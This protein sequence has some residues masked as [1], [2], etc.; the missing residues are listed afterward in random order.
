VD[1]ALAGLANYADRYTG[2]LRKFLEHLK[3][4]VFAVIV[5]KQYVELNEA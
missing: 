5:N 1:N 3:R 2:L 4:I